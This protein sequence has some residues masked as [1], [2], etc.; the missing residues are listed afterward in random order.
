MAGSSFVSRTCERC[1]PHTRSD[2]AFVVPSESGDGTYFVCRG[3]S[4]WVWTCTCP[5]FEFRRLARGDDCKHIRRV[6]EQH[7]EL[8]EPDETEPVRVCVLSEVVM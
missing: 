6:K 4:G 8:V 7:P 1:R 2:M 5:D 3:L